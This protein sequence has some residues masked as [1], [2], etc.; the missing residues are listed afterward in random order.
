MAPE[1]QRMGVRTALTSAFAIALVVSSGMTFWLGASGPT[2]QAYESSTVANAVTVV[3]SSLADQ[4]VGAV[5]GMSYLYVGLLNGTVL[6]MDSLTGHVAGSVTLPDGNSA[7]HLTYYNGAL[8]VGTEW[9]LYSKDK[10]PFHVYKIDSKTMEILGQVPM[11][12]YFANGFVMAFSGFLWAGDGHCTLYKLDPTNLKVIG[13]VPGMAEDEMTFDGANYWAECLNKV[14]VLKPAP[15]L[16]YEIASGSLAFPNRPRG[17]FIV[18]SGLYTAGSLDFKI[19]AMSL[20]GDSVVFKST[21]AKFSGTLPTRDTLQYGGLT[22]AYETGPGADYGRLPAR[23]FVYDRDLNLLDTVT[24]PGAA[25]S[26]DA[27]QHSLFMFGGRLYFVTQSALGYIQPTHIGTSSTT[28][29]SSTST[30]MPT[31]RMRIF[32]FRWKLPR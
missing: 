21:A 20:S 2:A 25:L 1:D 19:Y 9:L 13:T 5:G 11:E 10:A 7:A 16:P 31:T 8:Y 23:I 6:K 18:N 26:I 14:N 3:A 32:H 22:Y 24:I 30:T 4:F 27:S 17:F 28:S 29:I 15:T 12:S